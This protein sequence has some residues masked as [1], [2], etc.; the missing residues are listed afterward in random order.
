[1]RVAG[2]QS[3]GGRV[4]N[5]SQRDPVSTQASARVL[6]HPVSKF[7]KFEIRRPRVRER[8]LRRPATPDTGDSMSNCFTF[9]IDDDVRVIDL[10]RALTAAGLTMSNAAPFQF[11]VHRAESLTKVVD[12]QQRR[13]A[14]ASVDSQIRSGMKHLFGLSPDSEDA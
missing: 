6:G 4:S 5:A 12:L 2:L 3:P 1:M 10:V 14:I 8:P 7:Q 11:R 13:A 9:T